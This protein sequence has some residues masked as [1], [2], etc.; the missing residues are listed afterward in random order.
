MADRSDLMK[1]PKEDLVN[2]LS[3][4]QKR[5]RNL[6]AKAAESAETV[7][8]L[9]LAGAG[10]FGVGYYV[11]GIK[12]DIAAGA[13]TEE[14]LKLF[15]MDKDLLAGLVLAGVGVTGLA[16]KKTSGYLT[17]AGTGVLS[18]WAGNMGETMAMEAEG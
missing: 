18:Y 12:R 3:K 1:L 11:G 5:A 4:L 6:K 13:A 10:A 14:D 17:A 16:G 8:D 7:M 15:G 2:G 9:A